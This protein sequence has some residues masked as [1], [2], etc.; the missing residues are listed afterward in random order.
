MPTCQKCSSQFPNSL[1][2]DGKAR[3]LQRRKYCI[4]CSAFGTHNTSQLHLQHD[5]RKCPRC[6]LVLPKEKFYRRRGKPFAST[7][8]KS[9]SCQQTVERQ[10]AFKQKCV[11][12]KGGCCQECGYK[13][14][15]S[16]LEFHHIHP[17]HKDFSIA[18]AR[19]TTFGSKVQ[20]ELD[21]CILVCANCH[22]EI[23]EKLGLE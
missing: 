20:T 13:K 12:Y 14:C 1:V 9:C 5:Q 4:Q 7:Y 6:N 15:L 10:R 17:E 22:R 19:L 3:N 8:C 16:A 11:D 23:H 2:I 21:K 18:K